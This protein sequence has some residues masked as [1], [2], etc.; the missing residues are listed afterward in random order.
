MPDQ[1]DRLPPLHPGE[2]LRTEFLEPLNI[3]A[4][5]LAKAIHVPQTRIGEILAGRRGVTADTSLR[6]GRFFGM[7]PGFWLVLQNHHDMDVAQ[8]SLGGELEK[9]T[10]RAA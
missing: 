4:Y 9:I 2:I 10:P 5:A 3:S 7:S 6:L 1:T 8:D